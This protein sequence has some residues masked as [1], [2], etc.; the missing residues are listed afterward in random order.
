MSE[1]VRDR[2]RM[3]VRVMGF[4]ALRAGEV[5]ALRPSDLLSNC[6]LRIVRA[7][8][9][10]T[11]QDPYVGEPKTDAG[12]RSPTIACSLW[13][14]LKAFADGWEIPATREMF[15][16]ADRAL[17][18]HKAV[19]HAVAGAGKRIGLDVNS[20]QL[21][22]SAVS[23]LINRGVTAN[24]IQKFVGHSRIEETLGTYGHL[25]DQSGKGVADAME[26]ELETHRNGG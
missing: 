16:G 17:L 12:K 5:A 13:E 8:N 19:N 20:H 26:D 11:G 21:R 10:V 6:R 25:F 4:A 3:L 23:I 2:D 1:Y 9:K 14:D 7:V 18:H 15:H 22:H 24:Q